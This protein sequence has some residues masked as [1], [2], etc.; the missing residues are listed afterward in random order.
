MIC[1]RD[2]PWT[3]LRPERNAGLT[4]LTLTKWRE[5]TVQN[6]PCTDCLPKTE[7]FLPHFPSEKV[8]ASSSSNTATIN[9]NIMPDFQQ[10]IQHCYHNHLF[11]IKTIKKTNF[12]QHNNLS[13]IVTTLTSAKTKTFVE[14][15]F[16]PFWVLLVW[17]LRKRL[18][19]RAVILPLCYAWM[20]TCLQTCLFQEANDRELWGTQ[21]PREISE[22]FFPPNGGICFHCPLNVSILSNIPTD[23]CI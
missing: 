18:G 19:L 7:C 21:C 17:N 1:S 4:K 14:I 15:L 13:W 3:Y 9:T 11:V 8:K 5:H 2:L 12:L 16:P 10:Q 20:D 22:Q 23:L 6:K